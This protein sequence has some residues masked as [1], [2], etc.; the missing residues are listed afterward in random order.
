MKISELCAG[1]A[2]SAALMLPAGPALAQST[3]T[4]VSGVGD[5]ANPCTRAA[6]CKTFAGA[7]SRT[8]AGGEI[9]CID[10][11]GFG[12][13]MI[14]KAISIICSAGEAG[15]LAGG[16]DGIIIN[17]GPADSV[18]LS[19]LDFEGLNSGLNGINFQSGGSLTL[20]NASIRDFQNDGIRFAPNSNAALHI[21]NTM[22]ANSGQ[23]G[24][25]AGIY[26]QPSGTTTINVTICQTQ[27]SDAAYGIVADGS[28]TTGA[29]N[30]V[31]RDSDI[32]NNA[33]N[34]ITTSNGT[35]T[36]ST[37]VIDH[38][39]VSGNGGSGL[40]ATGT[41]AGMLVGKSNVFGNRAGL[42]ASAGGV[43]MSYGDNHVVGNN[44]AG[45]YFTSSLATK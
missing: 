7:I 43:L 32:S 33:A 1:L 2:L 8:V 17:A 14:T 37:L 4:W 34:G 45:A 5:D 3:R 30:G 29:I 19:G 36:H 21:A 9:N 42:I 27:V 12:V 25:Y 18:V 31:I 24:S 26:I 11:G 41:N 15:V 16:S 22:I 23:S 10:A 40:V 38:T 39:S 13:L 6:P 28:V 20:I 44:G 35:A